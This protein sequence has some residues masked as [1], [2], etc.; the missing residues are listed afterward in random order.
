MN[1]CRGMLALTALVVLTVGLPVALYRFGGSPVPERLPSVHQVIA[2]LLHKDN[3]TLAI[4]A[5]RDV[6]WLAWLG[7]A[8]SPRCRRRS[9]GGGHRS[10]TSGG[11]RER[12]ASSW[13][14]RR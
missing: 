4:A 8:L 7:F 2:G 12:L 13:R 3:G 9:G 5:I 6:S 14:W 1:R 10:C 11:C